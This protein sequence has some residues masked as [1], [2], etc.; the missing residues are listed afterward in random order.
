MISKQIT[1]K[2]LDYTSPQVEILLVAIEQGI[3][4]TNDYPGPWDN[5]QII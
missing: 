5:E 2:K 1:M 4:T 3:A